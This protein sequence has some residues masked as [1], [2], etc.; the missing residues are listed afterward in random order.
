MSTTPISSSIDMNKEMFLKLFISQLKHQDPMEPM[1]NNQMMSQISQ[2]SSLEQLTNIGSNF[3]SMLSQQQEELHKQELMYANTLLGQ[4][5]SFI[6]E[7]SQELTNAIVEAVKL[8]GGEVRL[9][10]GEYDLSPDSIISA[11]EG[12]S[13]EALMQQQLLVQQDMIYANSLLGREVVFYPPGA[14]PET[15]HAISAVVQAVEMTE[16]GVRLL[17]GEYSLSPSAIVEVRLGQGTA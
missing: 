10:A 17:A 1:D 14:D 13:F 2:L 8:V 15:D 3:E 7:D 9:V 11:H 5:V 6:D 12:V 4:Q 16:Q